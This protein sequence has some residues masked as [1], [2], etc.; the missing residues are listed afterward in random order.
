[1]DPPIGLNDQVKCSGARPGY[2]YC[3][4]LNRKRKPT[5]DSIRDHQ[6]TCHKFWE[7]AAQRCTIA[8]E[9][10]LSAIVDGSQL[11]GLLTDQ[12]LVPATA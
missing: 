4:S 6:H 1:M 2:N 7:T 9:G 11:M 3:S 8:L 10:F 12:T 5:F